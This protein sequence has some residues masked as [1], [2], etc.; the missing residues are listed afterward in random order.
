M[1]ESRLRL[2]KISMVVLSMLAVMS[3][4]IF[5]LI[6]NSN[7]AG[8]PAVP[9]QSGQSETPAP[10]PVITVRSTIPPFDVYISGY[11]KPDLAAPNSESLKGFLVNARGIT[12]L[13]NENGFFT[14]HTKLFM[15]DSLRLVIS[16]P[17]YLE[18]VIEDLPR[19]E[20]VVVGPAANPIVMWGG[21]IPDSAG[22]QD[23]A[24]NMGDIVTLLEGF[25]ASE[26]DGRY[27]PAYDLDKDHAVNMTDIVIIISHFNTTNN[28][29]PMPEI[30]SWNSSP[31]PSATVSPTPTPTST[32][33]SAIPKRVMVGYWHN[34][35]NGTGVIKLR[36]VS[37][38]WDVINLSFGEPTSLTSGIIVFKPV[39]GTDEEFKSDVAYLQ[40]KGKKVL[41][42]IGGE[43]GTVQ[44]PDDTAKQNFINSV[45]DIIERYGLDGL[46]IDFEGH[47]LYFNSGDTDLKNPK[48]PVIVNLISALR[49]ITDRFGSKCM[50]TMAPETFYVQLGY[51][52]YGG[53]GGTYLPVLHALRDRLNWLQVQYYNSGPIIGLDNEYHN[54]GSADF[55]VAMTDM[56]ING[57]PLN[58]DPNNFFPGLRPDQVV[59][60]IPA[61]V[62]AGNGYVQPAEVQKA[63]DYLIKGVS[64]G[65]SYKLKNPA[66]YPNLRGLMTWS[67]NWDAFTNFGFS[68]SHRPYLDALDK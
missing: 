32:P 12:A 55:L 63:L 44:L 1:K 64:F 52:T 2:K 22:S 62:N 8:E 16:K 67:I 31:T 39:Y 47:S 23:K 6:L 4:A 53:N 36:D 58:K 48:T 57:F 61:C 26:G 37:P 46:D 43:K 35:N 33:T 68:N 9:S 24:I 11:I 66:G 18:R 49:T 17:G 50:L 5:T 34:F 59:I 7:A 60:G 10:T 27:N 28:Q 38:K 54:M 21:D 20:N 51:T 29:Y 14:M 45:S 65:G 30:V 40:S 42:S 25:N 13:T 3:L 56:T 15:Y 41:L 19:K